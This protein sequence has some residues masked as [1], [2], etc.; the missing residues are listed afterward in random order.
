RLGELLALTRRS[1]DLNDGTISVVAQLQELAK[2]GHYRGLPKS[3][4][5]RRTVALPDVLL[6]TLE[7]HLDRWV[8]ADPDAL[9]FGGLSGG[10]LRRATFYKAWHKATAQVELLDFRFH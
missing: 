2:G 6:P 7:S 3:E 8:G 5:G 9:I 4:A 1:I 10:P